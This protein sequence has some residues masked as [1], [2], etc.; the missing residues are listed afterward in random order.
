MKGLIFIV[1]VLILFYLLWQAWNKKSI[2]FDLPVPTSRIPIVKE[3]SRKTPFTRSRKEDV[4]R[5]VFEG[6]F[7][8]PFPTKRPSFLKNPDTG[9]NLELDGFNEDLMLA[10]EYDGELHYNFPNTFH[11]TI[12]DFQRQVKRDQF[13]NRK[14]K[15]EGVTLI[16]IPYTV[17][18]KDIDSYIKKKLMKYSKIL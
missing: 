4:C 3:N 13:K 9:R 8:K 15:K 6:I 1:I 18:K 14:C 17:D 12:E 10:F 7:S 11:K 5:L 2:D 16:R